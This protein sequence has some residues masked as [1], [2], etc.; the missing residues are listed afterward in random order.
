[1][2]YAIGIDLG[3]VNSCVAVYR[4]NKVD[5]IVNDL[6]CRT[7]PSCVFI[8]GDE[9]LVGELAK[10]RVG[11]LYDSKRLIGK[12][13]NDLDFVWD[14]V[15]EETDD[16]LVY[17]VGGNFY[18][19]EEVS[20]MILAKMKGV[21]EAY[22]G[23]DI[24]DVVV[25]VP[26]YFG[27]EQRR[28]TLDACY[29]A[30]LNVLRLV[31]EPTAAAIAYGFREEDDKTI[32]VFDYGGGTVDVSILVIGSGV[33]EV[34]ATCGNLN[35][36]GNDFDLKIAKWCL[37]QF[38]RKHGFDKIAIN[39]RSMNRL[40]KECEM[41]KRVLSTALN[42]V[43]G[44]DS[45]FEGIDLN[46]GLTRAVFEDL[47]SD[48]LKVCLELVKRGLHMA[49]FEVGDIDDIIL[50][51]GSTRVPKVRSVIEGYFDKGVV[52]GIDPDEAVAHGAAIQANM[53]INKDTMSIVL[54]DVVPFALGI[55]TAGGIFSK[56][57]D[58]NT[59]VPCVRERVV[60]TFSDNQP[61]VKIKVYEGEGNFVRDNNLLGLF[62]LGD[63]PR[64][65]R[66]RPKIKVKFSVDVN[67]VLNISATEE[68][69]DISTSL[70]I[71]RDQTR[72]SDIQIQKMIQTA[73]QFEQNDIQMIQ[74]W[75][76]KKRIENYLFNLRIQ[77]IVPMNELIFETNIWLDTDH[78][79][80]EYLT[81]YETILQNQIEFNNQ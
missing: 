30:G 77:N 71:K 10:G 35:M 34:K 31:N 66:G 63:I 64:M 53:L 61:S 25:T 60:S 48:D 46:I 41:A 43:I 76:A 12:K 33:F 4:N 14:F 51:G 47:I 20:A 49:N 52:N 27:D 70:I 26:A 38:R 72:L 68:S 11:S 73:K 18:K 17:N 65:L 8:D 44:V 29:V 54:L 69:R 42:V 28:A 75:K 39:K 5:T 59:V 7:T 13:Y 58:G 1:M 2:N 3:T 67:G 36:G 56:V 37:E 40:L 57:V 6:G 21:A 55:E 23:C 50:V 74:K 9:R 78:T 24:K 80:E 22:L 79:L 16:G 32:L 19:V 15:I 45:F 81:K 62:E